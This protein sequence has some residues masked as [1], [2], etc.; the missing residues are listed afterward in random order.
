MRNKENYK[1]N[2]IIFK[3]INLNDEK[4]HKSHQGNNKMICY[5]QRNKDKDDSSFLTGNS[6]NGK[7]VEQYFQS[8]EGEN[9]I[10]QTFIPSENIFQKQRPNTF[11]DIQKL[12]DFIT[13]RPSLQEIPKEVSQ[14]EGSN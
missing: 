1:R 9:I 2:N 6:A 5:I 12:K 14:I 4:N 7:M 3:L 13:S 10:S 8:A 11:S